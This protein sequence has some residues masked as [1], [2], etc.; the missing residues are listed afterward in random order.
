MEYTT[1]ILGSFG[2]Q[3][4]DKLCC[5]SQV[6]L[7]VE[8]TNPADANA[9]AVYYDGNPVGY[10]AN[11]AKTLLE[12]TM[13]ATKLGKY[14]KLKNIKA[15]HC[16]LVEETPLTSINGNAQKRFKAKVFFV[17]LRAAAKVEKDKIREYSVAGS[18][19][20]NQ[21]SIPL[22]KKITESRDTGGTGEFDVV[23]KRE[24]TGGLY[25]YV[26]YEPGESKPCGEIKPAKN[27]PIEKW[28][29]RNTELTGKTTGETVVSKSGNGGVAIQINVVFT[30]QNDAAVLADVDNAI[31]RCA[32][33]ADVLQDKVKYMLE[34]CVE[35]SVLKL[36]LARMNP[37]FGDPRVPQ[38]PDCLF[39]CK[40][41]MLNDAIIAFLLHKPIR[42]IGAKGSGKNTIV[43]TICWLLNQ[44]RLRLQGSIELD[45]M[46]VFGAPQLEDGK[47]TFQLSLVMQA[48]RDGCTVVIDEANLIRPD[49]LGILHS[50]TDTA[51]A[52]LVPGYGQV[53]LS[54]ISSIVYTMNE[55]YNGTG[56]MNEATIDRALLFELEPEVNLSSIL[57]AYPE[58]QVAICQ[59]VSDQIRKAVEDGKLGNDCI[60]IRGYID[61]LDMVK[62]GMPIKRALIHG[63]EKAQE[64]TWRKAVEEIINVNC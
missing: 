53:S 29:T 47:T 51:R 33:Q 46:D 8:P 26:V 61:A 50:A 58:D 19:V 60:T 25:K 13:S 1:T 59:K 34:N 31:T 41:S 52:V 24:G 38:K 23:I 9:V 49:V 12:N 63:I 57:A 30:A 28:F 2:A 55:G 54:P 42:F 22:R 64:I 62:E 35:K 21:G 36:V 7:K 48:L 27:D 32:G 6:E 10:V 5:G 44:P 40:T 39:Q 15:I 11:S 56:D 16:L 17:P 20:R 45:K 14:F 3:D 18:T 4:Y 37:D 43:E